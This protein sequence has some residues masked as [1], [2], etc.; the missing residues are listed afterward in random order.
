MKQWHAVRHCIQKDLFESFCGRMILR[1]DKTQMAMGNDPEETYG[2]QC[3]LCKGRLALTGRKAKKWV[4][5]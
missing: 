1:T 4:M 2:G 5:V 3:T